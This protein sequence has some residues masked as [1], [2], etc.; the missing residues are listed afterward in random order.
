LSLLKLM[1]TSRSLRLTHSPCSGRTD[2]SPYVMRG[3]LY[4][5][6]TSTPFFSLRSTL[7]FMV[8]TIPFDPQAY[9]PCSLEIVRYFGFTGF[10]GS[11]L[12]F[13]CSFPKDAWIQKIVGEYLWMFL[14]IAISLVLYFLLFFWGR[15]HIVRSVDLDMNREHALSLI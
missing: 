11:F 12:Q 5:S 4:L 13:W 1:C 9:V 15:G 14:A 8:G 7:E 10:R 3:S 6:S 2:P